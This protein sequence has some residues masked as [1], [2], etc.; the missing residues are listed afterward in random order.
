VKRWLL[1]VYPEP[2]RRRYEDELIDVLNESPRP[3]RDLLDVAVHAGRLR[4]EQLM[5]NAT[6]HLASL[7]LAA[8]IFVLG[9]AINDL[10]DGI[11]EIPHHW[12]ST[13]A[14]LLVVAAAAVRLTIDARAKHRR[15]T[16]PSAPG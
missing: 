16:S 10:Q 2:F 9:Y 7:A 1:R 14:V 5:A 3:A 4:G 15:T 6:R 13:S 8:S 11:I 12:W